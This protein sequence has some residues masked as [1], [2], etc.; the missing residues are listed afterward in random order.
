MA[1]TDRWRQ[2]SR[3]YRELMQDDAAPQP[4]V[5]GRSIGGYQVLSLLG[6]GGMGDVYRARDVML[7]RDVA[8]KILPDLFASA[9][10]L[11]RFRREAQLLASLNHPNIAQI[12][13]LV[14]GEGTPALVLELV[15][16][17]TL[18]EI[19]ARG[20]VPSNDA[21]RIARQIAEALHFAHQHGIVHR[22]LKPAN[23]TVRRD[24]TVKVLDF[25]LAKALAAPEA[26]PSTAMMSAMT[27]GGVILGTAAYMAPE[28]A[29][30]KETDTRVDVWAFGVVLYEMLTGHS[31]FAGDTLVDTLGAVLH[32]EPEWSG[33]PWT[34]KPLLQLCLEKNH[35]R[36]LHSIGDALG[37]LDETPRQARESAAQTRWL[38]R[39]AVAIVLAFGLGVGATYLYEAP[40]AAPQPPAAPAAT[41]RVPAPPGTFVGRFLTLS[42]DA[43]QLAFLAADADRVSIWVHS[44][45]WGESRRLVAASD[46]SGS[47]LL[48]S[49]DGRYIGYVGL[50]GM[51]KKVPVGGGRPEPIARV[52]T[53][54]GG[55]AWSD[56]GVIVF[57]TQRSG[58]WRV[59]DRGGEAVPITTLDPGR[60]EIGHGAPR[61][62]PDG[63]HFIYARASA[64]AGTSGIYVGHVDR[65]PE[66]QSRD[67]L[68]RSESRPVYAPSRDPRRG[69]I[70]LV[71][72]QVLVAY[73]FDAD[74]LQLAGDPVSMV[75]G[76]GAVTSGGALISSIS[77]S[78]TGALAYAPIASA[79]ETRIDVVYNWM[80]L[81]KPGGASLA[82]LAPRS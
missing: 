62:L 4:S 67:V 60:R 50:D 64:R 56:D 17:S 20:P 65:A 47:S 39:M 28:Q 66:D 10:D 32:R 38:P 23:I 78:R 53:G 9:D 73:P 82:R 63:K 75:E 2:F 69:H 13:G 41:L 3:L 61:F 19:I 40:A 51:L 44:L 42:P 33:L 6:S 55:G 26:A 80:S 8:L 30:G 15:E 45:D 14:D 57:G 12:Y 81:L 37:W 59:S 7:G 70:L 72:N 46:Y 11:A 25:G 29:R 58:L 31:P 68:M 1:T 24:G 43:R 79:P 74:T 5:V 36:R 76:V 54:W 21:C 16:G 52:P 35:E 22:D 27:A 48:W 18:A 34:L 71:T 49:P 77:A